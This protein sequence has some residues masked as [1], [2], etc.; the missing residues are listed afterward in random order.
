MPSATVFGASGE[1]CGE[2][3]AKNKSSSAEKSGGAGG[4]T[5]RKF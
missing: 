4:L 5:P 1:H 3:R 2:F